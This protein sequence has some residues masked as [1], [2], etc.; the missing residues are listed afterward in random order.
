MPMPAPAPIPVATA[1]AR[2]APSATGAYLDDLARID[3][4]LDRA[5]RPPAL[6]SPRM[7]VPNPERFAGKFGA[8]TN[9]YYTRFD[10]ALRDNWQNALVL[11]RSEFVY[12][13]LRHRQWPV[14][15]LSWHVEVDDPKDEDQRRAADRLTQLIDAI[16]GLQSMRLYL[17][18]HLWYGKYAAQ[19]AWGKVRV[20]G[21]EQTTIVDHEPVNGDSLVYKH[22]KTPGVM[23]RPDWEPRPADA[24]HVEEANDSWVQL[25]DRG[26]A[27]FLYDQYWRDHFIISNFEPDGPDFLFEGDK[28]AAIFGL[29]LRGRLYWA[30]ENR[31]TL[32]MWLYDALQRIGVNGMLYGFYDLGN[33]EAAKRTLLA[34]KMLIRDNVTAF[35]WDGKSQRPPDKIEHIEPSNVGYEILFKEI[36]RLEES[37][38]RAVLGQSLSGQAEATGLGSEVAELHRTTRE[39]VIRFDADS[40]AQSLTRDLIG[41][42]IRLN[43]WEWRGQTLRGRLP[44]RARFAF[45]LDRAN[46]RERSEIITAALGWGLEISKEAA[47]RDTGLSP[48]K[49]PSDVLRQQ[50]PAAPGMGP[51]G[52]GGPDG[53]GAPGN[54]NL[55]DKLRARHGLPPVGGNG[56]PAPNGKK[57]F[58]MP[59]AGPAKLPAPTATNGTP[60]ETH[61]DAA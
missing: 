20:D 27:L 50:Q 41:P 18:N 56:K 1:E 38:R 11:T 58:A 57:T 44:F 40:Q 13:L 12:E 54:G 21:R 15:G 55:L 61:H 59:G 10:E 52:P 53:A 23:V 37:M 43:D 33:P 5:R 17:S 29:G 45:D 36:E 51:G 31:E 19:L 2:P 24:P 48:P 16:P 14:V 7:L 4:L 42:L 8:G 6:R 39:Q 30:L 28:A 22:D 9:T 49:D 60:R 34:L 32:R 47:Y 26:R 25:T 3:A 46:A 35:P